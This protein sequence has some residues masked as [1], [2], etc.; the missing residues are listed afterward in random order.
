M[1]LWEEFVARLS[2]MEEKRWEGFEKKGEGG[3]WGERERE[4]ESESERERE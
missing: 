2:I 1:N 4:R 3:R